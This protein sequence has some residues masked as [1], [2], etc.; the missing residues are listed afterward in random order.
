MADLRVTNASRHHPGDLSAACFLVQRDRGEDAL[1]IGSRRDIRQAQRSQQCVLRVDHA[2]AAQVHRERDAAG[3]PHP[4]GHRPAVRHAKS[5]RRLQRVAG[6][7]AVVEDRPGP[8]VA[9]VFGHDQCLCRHAPKYHALQHRQI[10][11]EESGRVS[12]QQVE[13]TAVHGDGVLYNLGE[14]V[15]IAGTR[16]RLDRRKVGDHGRWLPERT[17]RVLRTPGVHPRLSADARVDHR[18][19]RGGNGDEADAPLPHRSRQA[20]EVSDGATAHRDHAAPAIDLLP[21]EERQHVL[22]LKH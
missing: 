5:R 20:G 19:K 3:D 22:E 15:P 11:F 17:D 18:E 21:F 6:R 13:Q 12:L 9:L 14:G 1:G 4:E 10:A 7:V 16:Q 8:S 2:L